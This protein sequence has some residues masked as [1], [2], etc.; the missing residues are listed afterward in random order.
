[1]DLRLD[2]Y[3]KDKVNGK[4]VIE[5]TYTANT[6]DIFWGTV[7]DFLNILELNNAKTMSNEELISIAFNLMSNAKDQVNEL[8]M[9]IFDGITE[10]EIRMAKLS[11]IVEVLVAC[12][13]HAIASIN[14]LK[15]SKN[16]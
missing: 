7:E 15:N 13:K 11:N 3:S 4:R 9:D 5:K 12:F 10:A 6:Y 14:I 8:I 1:M 2:I 16:A